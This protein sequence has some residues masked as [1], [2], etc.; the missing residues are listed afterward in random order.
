MAAVEDLLSRLA[1]V[2]RAGSGW[3]ARCPSHEDAHNSLSVGTGDDGKV[4]LRCHAGCEAA[5]ILGALGL[6]WSDLFAD[7]LP[8]KRRKKG[9]PPPDG[10]YLLRVV[11][12]AD[13]KDPSG[14]ETW[15]VSLKIVD[16]PEGASPWVNL[17]WRWEPAG[18]GRIGPALLAL[19]FDVSEKVEVVPGSI[20][21]RQARARLASRVYGDRPAVVVEGWAPPGETV[22]RYRDESG[23]TLFEVVRLVPKAFVQRV[24]TPEGGYS[25][26]LGQ[27]RRVPYRLPELLEAPGARVLFVEGEKDADNAAAAGFL[28]T[29]APQGASNLH[30]V[31][32]EALVKALRGREVVV[33][34]DNDE[35]GEKYA[36]AAARAAR[37]AG[38]ASVRILRLPGLAPKGDLSDW[39]AANPPER[40]E[41][42]LLEAP[43]FSVEPSAPTASVV[44]NWEAEEVEEGGR[45][46]DVVV[47][48]PILDLVRD[49]LRLA[50]GWPR[51]LHEELFVESAS[52][53][54]L[55]LPDPDA[56]FAWLHGIGLVR[57]RS[58]VDDFGANF[59]SRAE[60]F[61]ALRGAARAVEDVSLV[62]LEPEVPLIHI[63]AQGRIEAGPVGSYETLGRYLEFF[64][65][66]G[67]SDAAILLALILTPF[68]GG[69]PG[70]RPLIVVTGPAG[71]GTQSTGKTALAEKAT[72]LA[73][74]PVRLK[75]GDRQD[76]P[77][78]QLL[79]DPAMRSRVVLLDNLSGVSDSPE[80]AELIT[81]QAFFGRPVFGKARERTNRMTWL[82]TAVSPQLSRDLADRSFVLHLRPADRIA[83]PRW[84]VR[85]LEFLEKERKAIV[86]EALAL[87]AD[88]AKA[89]LG[90]KRSRFPR[91]DE[92][93]LACHADAPK[94]LA[95]R[96]ESLEDVNAEIEGLWVWLRY[97][98]EKEFVGTSWTKL[99]P[100]KAAETWN[101]ANHSRTGSVWISRKLREFQA[102][103]T[104]PPEVVLRFGR[105]HGSPWE[106]NLDALR[107]RIRRQDGEEGGDAS[108]MP[109]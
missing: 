97:L 59:V 38:A 9:D 89:D 35:A 47:R 101:E 20:L 87:L 71:T 109:F 8:R 50:G 27:V 37:A 45:R 92:E 22:Y 10:E 75:I 107:S 96:A 55:F 77:T 34:P 17:T 5:A 42:L 78:R 2:E 98:V 12:V 61:R 30:K 41:G 93:V 57:W 6:Q 51:R 82:A 88:P 67:A 16:P 76:P 31:D 63:L 40:L 32:P 99:S 106:I 18:L 49:I 43:E 7:E 26:G 72:F 25:Y 86:E 85:L 100:T 108:P 56:L 48:I 44:S 65:P 19:G 60:L 13:S 64:R 28:A 1:N 91:W 84:E 29:T 3:T 81:A 105:K 39:L 79:S 14:L 4:L 52:G 62:P 80:L 103:G 94:A 23:A 70:A 11:K 46:K 54:L 53:D 58:G 69:P 33:V 66:V 90:G 73:G 24:P 36:N 102:A 104:L 68:W 15:R 83:D 21:G 74:S 95:E